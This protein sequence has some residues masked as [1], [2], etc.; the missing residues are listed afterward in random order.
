MKKL[1]F[2]H[3]RMMVRE[4]QRLRFVR[5]NTGLMDSVRFAEQG[6]LVYSQALKTSKGST[7]HEEFRASI[8]TYLLYLKR[9]K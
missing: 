8:V 5:S 2:K 9:M 3:R 1:S 4:L 6:I 7:Y